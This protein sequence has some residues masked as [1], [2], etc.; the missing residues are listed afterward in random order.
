[1]PKSPSGIPSVVGFKTENHFA[2][3][4]AFF[5]GPSG[6]KRGLPQDYFMILVGGGIQTENHFAAQN[7]FFIGPSG[8]KRG[9][10][11][12]GR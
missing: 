1:M 6:L 10:V 8:L 9:L 2:A 11:R 4:N 7:T 5:I 3:Q 12:H